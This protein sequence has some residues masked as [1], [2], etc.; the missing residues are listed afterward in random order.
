MFDGAHFPDAG[1]DFI[2]E[3]LQNRK[4]TALLL[5]VALDVGHRKNS[6]QRLP[7]ASRPL[8]LMRQQAGKAWMEDSVKRVGAMLSV[9]RDNIATI[10]RFF[11]S[12]RASDGT[13]IAKQLEERLAGLGYPVWRD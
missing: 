3:Y 10:S 8:N 12:Y 6:S 1:N 2:S 9:L 4:K 7:K 5:P 13:D 11:I